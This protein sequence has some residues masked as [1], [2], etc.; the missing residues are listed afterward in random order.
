MICESWH[1]WHWVTFNSSYGEKNNSISF[2]VRETRS[3]G[4]LCFMRLAV[5]LVRRACRR[6]MRRPL[7]FFA[8][9]LQKT[10]PK[11]SLATMSMMFMNLPLSMHQFIEISRS[12]RLCLN[13]IL[14]GR[15][16]RNFYGAW[17]VE[18]WRFIHII[19]A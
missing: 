10:E 3:W 5:R 14:F 17:R 13:F 8:S 7:F 18:I 12:V 15:A 9:W 2:S 6:L 11:S 19:V 4:G 16:D 1:I